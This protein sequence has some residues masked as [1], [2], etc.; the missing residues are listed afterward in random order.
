MIDIGFYQLARRR[1]E[2][3]LAPLVGKALAAGHRLLIRSPD[4]ALLA[5]ID[6]ALWQVPA[7]G[8]VPHGID[9]ALGPDRAASQ[10]VLLSIDA[11]RA[12]NAADCLVQVGDDIPDDLTGLARV[13]FLFDAESL[14]TAR[15]R[16]RALSGREGLRPVYWREA[17]GGRFEKAG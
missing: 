10:P 5:R 3:V 14:P 15:A 1:A 12:V 13:L 4:A 17:E 2:A 9:R 8:F 11:T 6:D 7:D 16:W